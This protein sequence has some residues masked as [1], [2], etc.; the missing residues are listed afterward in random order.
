M[1]DTS[2]ANFSITANGGSAG[3]YGMRDSVAQGGSGGSAS[4]ADSSSLISVSGTAINGSRGGNGVAFSGNAAGSNGSNG[5]TSSEFTS[6]GGLLGTY[7]G[8]GGGGASIGGSDTDA[9]TYNG[10]SGGTGGGGSGGGRAVILNTGTQTI[11][12]VV[13]TS[14]VS[15]NRFARF[16]AASGRANSGGGGGSGS[17]QADVNEY[18]INGENNRSRNGRS[19][20]SGVVAIR[21]TV[22]AP[23]QV[24]GLTATAGDKQITLNWSAPTDGGTPITDYVIEINSGNPSTAGDWQPVS[25]GTSTNTSYTVTNLKNSENYYFRVSAVN[26]VGTGSASSSVQTSPVGLVLSLDA[27]NSSSYSGTGSTWTDLSGNGFNGTITGPT[28]I[29]ESEYFAFDGSN[30]YVD[31]PD[32]FEN[33]TTGV[34]IQAYVDFGSNVTD[35]W[36]RIIDIGN[37]DADSNI[38]F[39]RYVDT[40]QLVFEVVSDNQGNGYCITDGNVIDDGFADYAVTLGEDRCIIYVNGVEVANKTYDALPDVEIRKE[41]FIGK[42]NW[43]ADQF[44]DTGF[45]RIK[46]YNQALTST[47]INANRTFTVGSGTCQQTVYQDYSNIEVTKS[48]DNNYC[49]IQFKNVGTTQWKVPAEITSVDYL[50][51]AG[52]GGGGASGTSPS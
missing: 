52:G 48:A 36:E 2:S 30:D 49:I 24:T 31:L 45:K 43:A 12:D 14:S 11:A 15:T 6:G 50:V 42:S 34:T 26:A 7:S 51:V 46:I 13:Y 32:G 22:T 38:F 9:D 29:D 21:Y 33:F 1:T 28:Y 10:G 17:A 25:D 37:G 39:G 19:G 8:G 35:T 47:Q 41:N 23:S 16:F 27:A 20:G 40:D 4:V 5:S 3:Q 18:T 44:L